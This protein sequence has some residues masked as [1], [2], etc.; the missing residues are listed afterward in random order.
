[1]RGTW[2][3]LFSQDSNQG[4][5]TDTHMT[6]RS[7]PSAHCPPKPAS[8]GW[9]WLQAASLCAVLRL[10]KSSLGAGAVDP[11][12]RNQQQ[13]KLRVSHRMNNGNLLCCFCVRRTLTDRLRFFSSF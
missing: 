13:S 6:P 1:M 9:G 3:A 5:N 4:S 2:E 7:R 10:W 12:G 8:A 11:E